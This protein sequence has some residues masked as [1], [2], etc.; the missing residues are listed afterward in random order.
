MVALTEGHWQPRPEAHHRY[1]SRS[2]RILVFSTVYPP[3]S[4]GGYEVECSG[5]VQ[6][7]RARREVRRLTSSLDR[8]ANIEPSYVRRELYGLTPDARGA[9]LAPAATLQAM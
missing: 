4:F 5:V 6:R 2:M 7:L 3:V 1:L 8:A 9:L